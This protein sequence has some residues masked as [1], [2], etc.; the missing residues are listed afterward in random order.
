MHST[1]IKDLQATCTYQGRA[2]GKIRLATE[3][4]IV[5]AIKPH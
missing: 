3:E 2:S 4:R 1:S 5:V